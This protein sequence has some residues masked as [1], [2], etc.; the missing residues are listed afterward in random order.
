M[1]DHFELE[2]H[3]LERLRAL[4]QLPVLSPVDELLGM[5]AAGMG[6]SRRDPMLRYV[7]AL[8]ALR[9]LFWRPAR[10]HSFEIPIALYASGVEPEVI[11]RREWVEL[12]SD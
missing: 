7:F 9:Q 3:A 1:R 12:G 6:L 10:Q 2:A 11:V 5:D 4:L 8:E